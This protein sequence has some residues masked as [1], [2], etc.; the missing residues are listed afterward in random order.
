MGEHIGLIGTNQEF[1]IPFLKGKL[2]QQSPRLT[3]LER[4]DGLEV[5][6]QLIL[7]F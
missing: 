2:G 1:A 6:H 3:F 7:I 4:F 5:L